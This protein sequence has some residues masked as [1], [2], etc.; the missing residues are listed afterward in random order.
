MWNV[1]LGCRAEVNTEPGAW[2][3]VMGIACPQWRDTAWV[4]SVLVGD[5]LV[6]RTGRPGGISR[7]M[8]GLGNEPTPCKQGGWKCPWAAGWPEH[9][10]GLSQGEMPCLSWELHCEPLRRIGVSRLQPSLC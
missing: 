3:V 8:Q 1:A 6:G 4:R 7:G 10:L 5:V 2:D 9:P